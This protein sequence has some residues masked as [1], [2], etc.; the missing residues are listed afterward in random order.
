MKIRRCN[1]PSYNWIFN[2][3]NG[4]F[5]RWGKDTNDDPQFSPIGPEIADIEVSTVCG[6]DCPHCY[7]NNTKIGKHMS[8][9]MFKEIIDK[10]PKN[11]TQVA[12]GVGDY[13]VVPHLWDMMRYCR[14]KNIVPNITINGYYM[15]EDDAKLF[16]E[17]CGAV[18]VSN[19]HL[20]NTK[21]C[22]KM[23][24]EA[25]LEQINIHQLLAQESIYLAHELLIEAM[26]GWDDFYAIV[27]LGLKQQGRAKT[28]DS[29]PFEKYQ[30]EN[31]VRQAIDNNIAIGF[32]SCSA[33]KFLDMMKDDP[34]LPIYETLAEPCESTC[35]SIYI[36]VDGFV[37]PCSFLENSPITKAN[38]ISINMYT[39]K[40]FIK[41]V[42]NDDG[43]VSFRK[44]L[45]N[46][47][48]HCPV[49]KI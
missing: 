30:F 21:R 18:A 14:S 7:K 47:G 27:F 1:T 39:V 11:L 36:D 22:V 19:Y 24:K 42:W 35:F 29:Q 15:I 48:R 8:L 23:L 25:G 31:L 37:H 6:G 5:A 16:A 4:G 9:K 28:A 41:D 38:F 34:R 44:H 13:Q 10:F 33:H 3:E 46:G 32:D 49:Y 12:L 17:L 43:I 40:D 45:I 2:M 26:G 20:A